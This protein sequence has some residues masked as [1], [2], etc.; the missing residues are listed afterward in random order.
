MVKIRKLDVAKDKYG[1][2]YF[3]KMNRDNDILRLIHVY[4]YIE[5]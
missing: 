1:N 2:Y 3:I 5:E 4:K